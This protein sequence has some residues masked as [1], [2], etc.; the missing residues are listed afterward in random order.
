MKNKLTEKD[1]EWAAQQL[2][3]EVAAIKAVDAIESRGAGFYADGQPTILF[4]RHVFSDLTDHKYDKSHPDIS[5]KI[6]GGYGSASG[7]NQHSRLQKAVKLNAKV[8]KITK[9]VNEKLQCKLVEEDIEVLVN[10]DPAL[11]SA[12]WGRFQIMGFNYKK[13]GFKD[14]QSFINAMYIDEVEQL[15]AFVNFLK[16]T[17]LDKPLRAKNWAAFAKGYNGPGYAKNAYDVKLKQAYEKF[18]K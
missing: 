17:G 14:L 2:N 5:N 4:E 9:V 18:S 15:K 11:M 1:F 16:S 7:E 13:A 12:S 8:E 10:R 3:V 6:A